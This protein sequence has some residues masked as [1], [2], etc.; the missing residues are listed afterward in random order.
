MPAR[1]ALRRASNSRRGWRHP[2]R[3]ATRCR[4]KPARSPAVIRRGPAT[5]GADRAAESTGARGSVATAGGSAARPAAVLA[6]GIGV[7][8]RSATQGR[9]SR[10]P[11]STMTHRGDVRAWSVGALTLGGL[12]TGLTVAL[13]AI[14]PR[15]VG[16]E[17]TSTFALV[18]V[19]LGHRAGPLAVIENLQTGRESMY[20]L[21]DR[22]EEAAVVAITADR[23]VL[24]IGHEQVELR[25]SAS[26]PTVRRRARVVPPARRPAR[27]V[28]PPVS[29]RIRSRVRTPLRLNR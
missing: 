23:T 28:P 18:G 15:A 5:D 22:L 10:K 4:W 1:A 11:V 26:R 3:S 21:G 16:G 14:T 29:P 9:S 7:A 24:R 6:L 17:L 19:V 13:P 8:H 20:R 25:L 2:V 12:I 27:V